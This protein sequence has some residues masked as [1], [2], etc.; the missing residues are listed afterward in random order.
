MD[1]EQLPDACEALLRALGPVI[2]WASILEQFEDSNIC[3]KMKKLENILFFS[4]HNSHTN[5]NF[6]LQEVFIIFM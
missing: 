1:S 6:I 4:K 3:L 2:R 5:N